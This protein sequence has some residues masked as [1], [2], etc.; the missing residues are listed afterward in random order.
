MDEAAQLCD[1]LAIMNFGR[2]ITHGE[3]RELVKKY[4]GVT[5]VEASG[6][7]QVLRCLKKL[8]VKDY[9]VVG[10]TARIFTKNP[11]KVLSTLLGAC[12]I[13]KVTAR[14]ATLEDVFIKL[15]GKE[16]LE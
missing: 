13:G 7:P 3:P 10:G 6:T 2:I 5:V 8:G 4:A 11:K 12:G 9:D 1:R 14:E 15:T 16:L